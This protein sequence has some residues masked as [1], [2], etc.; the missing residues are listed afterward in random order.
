MSTA[1]L[2]QNMNRED[3]KVPEI[4]GEVIPQIEE[5]VN[6]IYHQ[7]KNG[8]RLFYIGSGTSG[9]LGIVDA[10]ECPPTYG[11]PHG[12]VIGLIA[13][14]EG[15]IHKAVEFAED[16]LTQGWKDLEAK[17]ISPQDFVIGITASGTT[18]Y[19]LAAMD[20]CR[21]AGVPTA[22]ITCN[23]SAPLSQKVDHPIEAVVGPE[24]VTGSTRMKAGTAQKL[25]L[26]MISTSVMVKLGH[27]KG[28][29]M[30]D[31]QLSNDKLVD[32]GTRMIMEEIDVPYEQAKEML[33]MHGSVR[34][35]LDAF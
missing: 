20:A 31:M 1:E 10:S 8:G 28:N 5:A 25:I 24:F 11:V 2:L 29:K 12:L 14:G 32:R 7:M 30:V 16:S 15:A 22:G 17:D 26:N 23:G 13:G 21:K 9:R 33:L 6:A 3:R 19:V 34:G 18:P 4:I 35:A 27:V